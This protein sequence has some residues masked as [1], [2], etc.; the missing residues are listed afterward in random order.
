M[1]DPLSCMC[2][3]KCASCLSWLG[4]QLSNLCSSG[5]TITI[6]CRNM[7]NHM[8]CFEKC[9]CFQS[10][11]ITV[12]GNLTQLEPSQEMLTSAHKITLSALE[13]I[14]VQPSEST[15]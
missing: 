5:S 13:H 15:V 9:N 6:T 4:G 1:L 11:T 8:N 7:F 10:T 3:A 2:T 14:T 12:L